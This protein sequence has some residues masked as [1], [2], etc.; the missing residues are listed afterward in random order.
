MHIRAKSVIF[1]CTYKEEKTTNLNELGEY[2]ACIKRFVRFAGFV[3]SINQKFT[4]WPSA[5]HSSF[6][7]TFTP[8]ACP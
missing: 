7:D 5:F 3:A 2:V 8:C 6:T 4:S 1:Q